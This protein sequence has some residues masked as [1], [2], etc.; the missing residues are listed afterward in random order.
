MKKLDYFKLALTLNLPWKLSW[1]VSAFSISKP[2][3]ETK[4]YGAIQVQDWGYSF[5]GQDGELIKIE[6]AVKGEPL[7]KFLDPITADSS[8]AANIHE[9]VSTKIGNVLFN[10]ICILSS[11]GAK[12]PFPLG[13]VSISKLEDAIAAKLKDTPKEGQ[14]RS[15]EYYYVDELLNFHKACRYYSRI[16]QLSTWSATRRTIVPATGITKFKRELQQKYE[17][18][19]TDPVKLTEYESELQVFDNKYLEGDP[20]NNTFVRGKIKNTARKKLFLGLGAEEGFTDGL[21]VTPVL[22]SLTEGW[23]TDPVQFTAM[24]NGLRS[25]SFSRG[26]ETVKGGVFAKILLRSS[27]NIRIIDTDC[28]S[29]MGLQRIF[30]AEDINQLVGRSVVEGTKSVFV[31]NLQA[32]GNYLGKSIRTR[33]FQYCLLEGASRCKVCAG[34]RLSQFPTGLPIALTSMSAVILASSLKKMHVGGVS[35]AKLDLYRALT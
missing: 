3:K 11:F 34:V 27:N 2:G 13:S 35:T 24:M 20:A 25:A 22:N 15:T 32:A 14:E 12:H 7:F 23:P 19:L 17:G 8:M 9:S 5:V 18:Q 10:H 26:A 6:D 4:E 16:S 1:L 29:T 30:T 28:G 33:S 31:E 21:T